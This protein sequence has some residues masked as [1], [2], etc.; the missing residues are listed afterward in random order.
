MIE[1]HVAIFYLLLIRE[2]VGAK[3]NPIGHLVTSPDVHMSRK[4]LLPF[5]D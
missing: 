4:A 3:S 2:L 5:F 1:N